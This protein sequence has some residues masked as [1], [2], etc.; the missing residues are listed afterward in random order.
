LPYPPEQSEL[1]QI[2]VSRSSALDIVIPSHF[3]APLARH[4]ALVFKWNERIH[5]T[6][7]IDP[8][9]AVERHILESV[10]GAAEVD[11]SAG[12]LLDIGSGNGYPG[13]AFKILHP[14]LPA[15]LLEPSLKKSVFL[16]Q[17][18]IELQLKAF[19]VS[20]SRVDAPVDLKA[21]SPL[22][23]ITM[24]AVAAVKAVCLGAA[25]ALVPGGR[26]LLY[27]GTDQLQE[28]QDSLGDSLK[29]TRQVLLPGRSRAHL[30]VIEKLG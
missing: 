21:F 13:L 20:R 14:G 2:L 10:I 7:V 22:G 28:A 26:L 3:I 5:L 1:E 23:T 16:R 29:M 9:A 18:G 12:A 19:E 8:V 6:S 17:V 24:R 25:D 30:A 27:L 15:K 11:T 4:L